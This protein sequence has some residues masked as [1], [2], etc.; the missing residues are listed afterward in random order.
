MAIYN[1]YLYGN[2]ICDYGVFTPYYKMCL[3]VLRSD[4]SEKEKKRK[5]CEILAH[6]GFDKK[7]SLKYYHRFYKF[8]AVGSKHIWLKD[9]IY[10]KGYGL[11]RELIAASPD[12]YD[13]LMAG[14]I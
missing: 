11:V 5:I 3:Q 4:L 1:E 9:L 13:R 12:A 8:C 2:K 7:R 14:D 10:Y 6:K